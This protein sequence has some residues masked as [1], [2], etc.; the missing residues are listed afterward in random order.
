M[1]RIKNLSA[2][3]QL[4]N[5]KMYNLTNYAFGTGNGEYYKQMNPLHYFII[6]GDRIDMI[7]M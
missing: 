4:K 5:R 1:M 7:N 2:K 3:R 6:H